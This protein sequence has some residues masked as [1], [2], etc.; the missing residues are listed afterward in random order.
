MPRDGQ[1]LYQAIP[2][3]PC[4]FS[5]RG[6]LGVPFDRWENWARVCVNCDGK[7]HGSESQ[8]DTASRLSPAIGELGTDHA[9][10]RSIPATGLERIISKSNPVSCRWCPWPC[11][12]T[13]APEVLRADPT[14]LP[15]HPGVTKLT[16]SFAAD[17]CCFPSLTPP[18]NTSNNLPAQALAK[19]GITAPQ[20]FYVERKQNA[21][22]AGVCTE[23]AFPRQ[24][25]ERPTEP[26]EPPS[27]P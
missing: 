23:S 18:V 20:N 9:T 16:F 21:G 12:T 17:L 11:C 13:G 1:S 25:A 24:T 6:V 22:V 26:R 19:D 8:R 7:A 14:C 2:S 3:V 5:S 10:L 4:S 15:P 27:G